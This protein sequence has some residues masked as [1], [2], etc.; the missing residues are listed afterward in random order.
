MPADTIASQDPA[1]IAEVWRGDFLESVHLGHAAVVSTDGTLV[2]GYGN[3]D[4][5]ILPRSS[6]KMIQGLPLIESGAADAIGLTDEHLALACASHHAEAAHTDRVQAWLSNIGLSDDALRCGRQPPRYHSYK[7]ALIRADKS[8]C[9]YHNNC[10]GKHTGFLTLGK[11]LGAGPEYIDPDHP[12]QLAVREAFEDVTGETSPGFGVDGCSAPNFACTLR[13][14][15]TAMA[16]FAGAS[17]TGS[18]RNRAAHRLALAMRTHPLLVSGTEGADNRLML[19]MA[20]AGSTKTGAEGVYIAILP[21]LGLGV[22]LKASD[23]A[24]R[25]SETAITAL[26]V[27]LGALDA[28]HPTAQHYLDQP[29]TNWRG[30]RTGTLKPA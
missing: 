9:Q 4:A 24:T 16:R 29:I 12:V 14:L 3:P 2:D 23:G 13:G 18:T 21:G 5:V 20:G 19:A 25:A 15:A 28:A 10:S 7:A 27:K 8:P 22:A 11:H 30:V 17:E 26:L 6:A 1:P